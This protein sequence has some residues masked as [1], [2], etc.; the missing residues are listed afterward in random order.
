MN[1]FLEE[2]KCACEKGDDDSKCL[3]EKLI[4]NLVQSLKKKKQW[5]TE[6]HCLYVPDKTLRV[7]IL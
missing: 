6:S 1:S 2:L 3:M 5:E 4:P 7:D